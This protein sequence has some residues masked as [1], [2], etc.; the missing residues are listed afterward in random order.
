M[1]AEIGV[2]NVEE[3]F[4]VIP[5]RLRLKR[6]L[7][8]PNPLLAETDLRKH[9]EKVLSKNTTCRENLNFLGAGCSQHFVPAV[10]DEIAHRAEFLTAYGSF[11]YTDLGKW[12]AYF[13]YQ[14]MLGEL[15]EMD[16]VSLPTYDSAIAVGFAL[17]MASRITGRKEVLIAKTI[18]PEKLSVVRNLCQPAAMPGHIDVKL[19]DYDHGRGTLDLVDLRD[20][21]SS[22]TAAVYFENP[23]YLG[24]V[25]EGKEISDLVHENGA[26]C[27]VGVDPISLGVLSPPAQYGADI[28]CGGLQSLGIHMEYGGLAGFI[29]S[30]EEYLPEY[31]LQIAGITS[32]IRKGEFGFGYI[33]HE[34]T[35]YI[36]REKGKDFTGTTVCLWA[37]VAAVYLALMGPEGMKE[38]GQAVIQKS[39]Y[40]AELLSKISGVRVLFS[41]HFFQEFVVNFDGTGRKVANINNELLKYGIFGGKDLTLEFPELG[42]S[43]LYSVTEIHTK[44][45]LQ[46][47][48][49]TL[50]VILK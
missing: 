21:L 47:L 45:D 11:A 22:K 50:R 42:N 4:D 30:G 40:A 37:I 41:P 15:L 29:A 38:I 26:T 27:V 44:N 17:R 36:E 31:P 7:N 39:H 1:L 35:L 32:T 28:V 33:T 2:T 14:S 9:V 5:D 46:K 49:D 18:S 43:A 6:D 8:L 34:R 48:A 13:E 3:L 24:S 20:K 10:C 16:V 12:Q 23:S 19:V 25:S